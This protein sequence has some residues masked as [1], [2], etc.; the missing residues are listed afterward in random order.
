M[1]RGMT[2]G[3]IGVRF[4]IDVRI[5]TRIIFDSDSNLIECS[6]STLSTIGKDIHCL[7]RVPLK[8]KVA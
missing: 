4:I 7:H 8:M 2:L 5:A 6:D 3:V 1:C